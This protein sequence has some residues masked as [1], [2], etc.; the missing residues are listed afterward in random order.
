MPVA[1]VSQLFDP[2]YEVECRPFEDLAD[3][4]PLAELRRKRFSYLKPHF[5]DREFIYDQFQTPRYVLGAVRIGRPPDSDLQKIKDA[6]R[7]C[8]TEFVEM[9]LEEWARDET[10]EYE[11]EVDATRLFGGSEPPSSREPSEAEGL[12]S[13]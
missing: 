1:P 9:V 5:S 4:D 6:L 11:P 7:T 8:R 12:P 13:D 2:S 10:R 3:W